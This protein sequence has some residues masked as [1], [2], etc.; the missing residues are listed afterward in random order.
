MEAVTTMISTLFK[1]VWERAM[2]MEN[3]GGLFMQGE[4]IESG[5]TALVTKGNTITFSMPLDL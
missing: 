5:S 3:Q 2:R 4:D 1:L